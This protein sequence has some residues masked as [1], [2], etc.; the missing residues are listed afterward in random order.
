[1]TTAVIFPGQGSQRPGMGA[2]L[3]ERYPDVTGRASEVLGLP[4]A[5][6]CRSRDGGK[7]DDTRYTQPAR[8]VVNA[9]S[10]TAAREDGLVLDVVLGHSV[11]EYSALLAAG[12]FGFE[13]G[14][15]LVMARAELMA[16][17]PGGMRA[18]KYPSNLI[19]LIPA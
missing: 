10:L 5:E 17:V 19:R 8:Y 3:F 15:R 11:G 2:G 18:E 13:A 1:M 16:G 12:V 14:L 7:L 4:I 6:L 9:L